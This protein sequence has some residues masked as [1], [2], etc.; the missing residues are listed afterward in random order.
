MI[1]GAI[2]FQKVLS[3]SNFQQLYGTQ[4]QCDAALEIAGS[5]G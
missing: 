1:R 2:Q 5:M 4:Q 3:M